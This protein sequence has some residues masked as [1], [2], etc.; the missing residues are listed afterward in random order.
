D[1]K[2]FYNLLKAVEKC[3]VNG[4]PRHAS[5][6]VYS[7]FHIMDEKVFKEMEPEAVAN[8]IRTKVL[9]LTN[10]ENSNIE[11]NARDLSNIASLSSPISVQDF[12]I[13]TEKP[14]DHHRVGNLQQILDCTTQENCKI[15]N[16]L[17]LPNSTSPLPITQYSSELIAWNATIRS[18]FCQPHEH[19]PTSDMS[20][21]LVGLANALHLGHIDSDGLGTVVEVRNRD[22]GKYW[23]KA[24]R[25]PQTREKLA[26][27]NLFIKFN[28]ELPDLKHWILEG[29]LLTN[30]TRIVMGPNSAH[31]VYTPF[32]TICSG[33]H[34]ISTPNM[35]DTLIGLIHTFML[36]DFIT[37]INHPPTRILFCRMATFYYDD[38]VQKKY[39]KFAAHGHVFN[40]QNFSG[41]LDVISFC[42]LIILINVLDFRTYM[43][44]G[45]FTVN[46]FKRL[47]KE[48]IA[49]IEAFDYNALS[50]KERMRY[51]YARGQAY[52]ILDWLF[53]SVEIKE[54]PS[55]KIVKN[56][57]HSL[58]IPLMAQQASALLVYKKKTME[59][60]L[61]G[62]KGCTPAALKRQ[63]LLCFQCTLLE[64]A[65]NDAIEAEYE[66]FTFSDPTGY[67]ATPLAKLKSALSEFIF[68]ILYFNYID[69]L[70]L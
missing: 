24:T 48:R 18:M 12:S 22:G 5:E 35:Q 31:W 60:E 26:N 52:A 59:A 69:K 6:G 30:K 16:V 43:Y 21:F 4:K 17:D 51:Q 41:V 33:G 65:V 10:C 28:L 56:P 8:I 58:W 2:N 27:V 13:V 47:T 70:Y 25:I 40:I 37:N 62:A 45:E 55:G 1:A 68:A 38:L 63:I 20:W 19:F 23:M 49:S 44:N 50:A 66:V 57:Y 36:D 64:Q 29:I 9:V 11:F 42:N 46:N 14:N 3:Y 32:H 7:N 15:L 34:Y 61:R 39:N 67:T 54:I 53:K